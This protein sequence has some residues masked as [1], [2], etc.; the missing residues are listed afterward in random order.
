[1]HTP[2]HPLIGESPIKAAAMSI[3]INVALNHSQMMFFAQMSRPSGILSTEAALT[4][5]QMGQ[6]RSAF[7]D[8][9]K[10]WAQGG[11][12][13]LSNGLKFQPT[14]IAQSDAQ[15]IE[16]QKMTLIDISRVFGVPH[17][18]LSEGAGPQGGTEAL[19][20][21]WLSVGLGSVLESIER[22]LER[23]FALPPHERIELD[24]SPL[25]RVDFNGRIDGLAKAVMGGVM[26]PNEARLREGLGRVT[27]GDDAFLQRQ[28]TPVSLLSE[29]AA[30]ELT[31]KNEPPPAQETP[32]QDEP[33]AEPVADSDPDVAKALVIS[34]LTRKRVDAA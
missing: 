23:L 30:A 12:P 6:L 7:A 13:I 4:R 1:M 32:A 31:A 18:L 14:G 22:S 29:L 9:S 21:H 11:I 34:M 20:S 10:M 25:L 28:Q 19:I 27:G 17:A 2:R 3:G 16:Q 26:T 15:L 33:E 24:P 5:E 8:Q